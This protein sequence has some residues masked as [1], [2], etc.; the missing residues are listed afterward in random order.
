MSAPEGR[1]GCGNDHAGE[2]HAMGMGAPFLQ[3]V[4]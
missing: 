4:G 3:H 2:R 1:D